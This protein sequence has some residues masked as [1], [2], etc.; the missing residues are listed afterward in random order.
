[1][2]ENQTIVSQLVKLG[3]EDPRLDLKD[4][5][6]DLV[7]KDVSQSQKKFIDRL[8]EGGGRLARLAEDKEFLE[9]A[10][11][12][13]EEKYKQLIERDRGD[14]NPA[15]AP[16]GT[17]TARSETKKEERLQADQQDVADKSLRSLIHLDNL[18]DDAYGAI[19]KYCEDYL[20]G[21]SSPFKTQFLSFTEARPQA[22]RDAV[23]PEH[24]DVVFS[25]T[26]LESVRPNAT[27][28][29]LAT[30]LGN[31]PR[32]GVLRSG[33]IVLEDKS[34]ADLEQGGA[35]LQR[36]AF[37]EAIK[38][39][40]FAAVSGNAERPLINRRLGGW[41]HHD[42]QLA[43][44][45]VDLAEIERHP[46]WN[47]AAAVSRT[48]LLLLDSWQQR[49]ERSRRSLAIPVDIL[50]ARIARH[51]G[52]SP[53]DVDKIFK[54][55][56]DAAKSELKAVVAAQI[57]RFQA[58]I[59]ESRITSEEILDSLDIG[60]D[61]VKVDSPTSKPKPGG[62]KVRLSDRIPL[63]IKATIEKLAA[64]GGGTGT[65][66][67]FAEAEEDFTKTAWGHIRQH[68]IIYWL[69]VATNDPSLTTAK[70]LTAGIESE[71]VV[72][73]VP[74]STA[75]AMLKE[76][77]DGF[78]RR[79]RSDEFV[80]EVTDYTNPQAIYQGVG[81]IPTRLLAS[82]GPIFAITVLLGFGGAAIIKNLFADAFKSWGAVQIV[83]LIVAIL[84]LFGLVT[85]I[86]LVRRQ[87]QEKTL[88]AV[89]SKRRLLDMHNQLLLKVQNRY[90]AAANSRVDRSVSDV[91]R[92]IRVHFDPH[93][94][95]VRTRW[96][97]KLAE[98]ERN[99]AHLAG[100]VAALDSVRSEVD[101]VAKEVG[102]VQQELRKLARSKILGD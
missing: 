4:E 29:V 12:H 78:I 3:K 34:G 48:A 96:A 53:A 77:L 89:T 88:F 46:E 99:Q 26:A 22:T 1:M 20:K 74:A 66:P 36:P 70:S 17:G 40:V 39:S 13:Y 42:G 15:D 64:G 52:V 75:E 84:L 102:S 24:A 18:A 9:N 67:I 69:G 14:A 72:A 7:D 16:R 58:A 92:R 21:D 65:R 83:L 32:P 93:W 90:I 25:P 45:M 91:L 95:D 68:I 27:D 61:I 8:K 38:G 57:K 62:E 79:C 50:K 43:I 98:L 2:F 11:R 47:A 55:I 63:Q 37:A 49:L 30:P 10:R 85:Y 101:R 33:I 28:A 71:P 94:E 56:E 19:S 86:S 35:T 44:Q 41:L 6:A 87:A 59:E 80:T 81:K 97:D 60:S 100:Q 5:I 31:F 23:P 51:Q 76:E 82:L 73:P 54:N